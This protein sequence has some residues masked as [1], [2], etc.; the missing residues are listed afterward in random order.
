M[1]LNSVY[2][3][4]TACLVAA[5]TPLLVQSSPNGTATQ[6]NPLA[7]KTVKYVTS[8][9]GLQIYADSN[10]NFGKPALVFTHGLKLTSAVFNRVFENSTF[11]SSFHLVRF[12]THCNECL[13]SL[14]LI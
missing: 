5:T 3:L 9:D 10:D 8:S 13:G 14:H 12:F 7:T 11:S 1:R 2:A 4:L 6:L